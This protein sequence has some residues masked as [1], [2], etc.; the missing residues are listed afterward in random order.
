MGV[1]ILVDLEN[2]LIDVKR[3]TGVT[4]PLPVAAPDE[5]TP[6]VEWLNQAPAGWTSGRKQGTDPAGPVVVMAL[7]TASVASAGVTAD[8][9]LDFAW[10]MARVLGFSRP[11][12]VEL[13]LTL[14][15]PQTADTALL[16]LLGSSGTSAGSGDIDAVVAVTLDL[17][18]RA[19]IR[20]RIRGLVG[21]ARVP[22]GEDFA[23][24]VIRMW[25][26]IVPP[27]Q[28]VLRT[29]A[30]ASVPAIEPEPRGWGAVVATEA[31]AAWASGRATDCSGRSLMDVAAELGGR[32]PLMSQ[33][34]LTA[35]SVRGVERLGNR[36]WRGTNQLGS[37]SPADGL[38]VMT[39]DA[40]QGPLPMSRVVERAS[41]GIG[42]VRLGDIHATVRTQLPLEIIRG[43]KP[44]YYLDPSNRTRLDDG[45]LIRRMS[46]MLSYGAEAAIRLDAPFSKPGC[47]R[48]TVIS[49]GAM[50]QPSAWWIAS[51]YG[52]RSTSSE[53]WLSPPTA[54]L[55]GPVLQSVPARMASTDRC[56]V[57][58]R[59]ALVGPVQVT[60]GFPSTPGAIA[61]ARTDEGVDVALLATTRL[62]RGDR[63]LVTNI[64]DVE[65][66]YL[67]AS[68]PG[69]DIVAL[70]ALPLV[71]AI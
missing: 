59:A 12:V 5:T 56:S 1:L 18:L 28:R 16:R 14:P 52:R 37:V 66:T 11:R 71:V 47:L 55:A 48:A 64:Q 41:I 67:S 21:V 45:A 7:N 39:A 3:R 60:V 20:T 46:S 10:A 35:G 27:V 49:K 8:W 6:L 2:L 19:L 22:E 29:D 51:A 33:L 43:V 25:A 58:F 13:C 69:V 38:E 15:M 62:A 40:P 4:R 54:R 57:G 42:A 63:V 36:L 65:R 26:P 9:V 68:I 44:P 70:E 24:H 50:G 32:P 34:G 17:G 61:P 53:C 31:G 30:T 23:D